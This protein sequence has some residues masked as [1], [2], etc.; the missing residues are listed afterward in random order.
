[1]VKHH[2]YTIRRQEP[3]LS[4]FDHFMGLALKR[5]NRVVTCVIHVLCI[6]WH[7]GWSVFI[8][9]P[10]GACHVNELDVDGIKNSNQT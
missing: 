2:T 5:L 4:V 8:G 9:C 10:Q 3:S 1:M 7:A 6:T